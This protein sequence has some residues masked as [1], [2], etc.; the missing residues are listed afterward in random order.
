MI[1]ATD[2]DTTV[3]VAAADEP[4]AP[5]VCQALR[6][7][8]HTDVRLVG[9]AESSGGVYADLDTFTP[10]V[11]ADHEDLVSELVEVAHEESVDAVFPLG[12]PARRAVARAR[13]IFEDLRITP[14][15]APLDGVLTAAD[16][17]QCLD[18][19]TTRQL[20]PVPDFAQVTDADE[21]LGGARALGYPE[22]SVVV[23]LSGGRRIALD[24][25]GLDRTAVDDLP[26]VTIDDLPDEPLRLQTV[27]AVL[28]ATTDTRRMQVTEA[29]PGPRHAVDAVVRDGD[30]LAA[31]PQTVSQTSEGNVV[32]HT[33][34]D[35]ALLETTAAIADELDL[36]YNVVARFGTGPDGTRRLVGVVP[37][38]DASVRLS[39]EAGVNTPGV[40]LAAAS[41]RGPT[42]PDPMTSVTLRVDETNHSPSVATQR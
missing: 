30:L 7:S 40:A 36:E 17:Q 41:G 1:D 19:L 4:Y 32:R 10:T 20:A 37:G 6:A 38:L 25:D 39:L 28:R 29:L 3:L 21:L 2:S 33:E 23:R 5:T 8:E 26:D 12:R 31:V 9:T 13:P 35:E 24:P 14:V 42:A 27:A 22:R 15:V 11:P 16:A 18:A 34:P